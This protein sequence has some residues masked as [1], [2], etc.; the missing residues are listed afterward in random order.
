[1]PKNE[2]PRV[3][4]LLSWHG[5]DRGGVHVP[6]QATG[7]PYGSVIVTGLVQK[8]R[9]LA[10]SIGTGQPCPRWIFM[11]GGP[12]NGK[13]E[14]VEDFLGQLDSELGM[15]GA[16]RAHLTAAFASAPLVPRRVE[17]RAADLTGAPGAFSQRVGR[18]VVVQDATATD[19][20][21]GNAA[22]QL[23]TDVLDLL[24]TPENPVPV[25]VACTN[26]GLLSRALKE[27]FIDFK[28][29]SP[30]TK[31]FAELIRSSSLGLETLKGNRPSCWPLPTFTSVACWPLDQESLLSGAAG[32]ASPVDQVLAKATELPMWE[33]PGRCAD[34]DAAEACPFRQNAEWLRDIDRRATLIRVLRHGELATGQRWNFRDTF[35][36]VAELL[37]GEWGDFDAEH[38]CKWVHGRVE[39]IGDLPGAESLGPALA[40]LS[41]LYPHALFPT[42]WN[43]PAA[44]AMQEEVGDFAEQ[45]VSEAFVGE[46]AHD[47]SEHPKP[48]REKLLQDYARF[49]PAIYTPGAS[50]HV[51]H[52]IETEYSQSVAVGNGVMRTPALA[53]AET[54]FLECLRMAEEEWNLLG[55]ESAVAT[56]FV[57]LL[58]RAATIL[59]KRSVGVRLGHHAYEAE[60]EEFSATLRSANKLGQLKESLRQIL[61]QDG[62]RFNLVESYGQPAA[63]EDRLVVL[64]SDRPGLQ[65]FPAPGPSD[66]APA[67]DVPCFS[68]G[69]NTNYRMPITFDF[70]LALRLRSAG[71]ANSSLPASVRAAIDRVRHRHAGELCRAKGKFADGTVRI[72]V[73]GRSVITLPDENSPPS[74][75]QA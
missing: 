32:A 54:R 5:H 33:T 15:G 36:L 55:R 29:N 68:I 27:A 66:S 35:S 60:L 17:V 58:R 23:A 46:L 4:E 12:G 7:N 75:S 3:K 1:M 2:N 51:L 10:H 18:L 31:L 20:A 61:G 59:V 14:T 6:F 8:L 64:E 48:I 56:K 69:S 21:L 24:T 37:V 19:D 28:G 11:I 73:G 26:R 52:Q 62:F 41:H 43:R 13:S 38:P 45:P 30:A 44:E 74:V 22:K 40:L 71:C 39:A 47:P 50:G 72:V 9:G 25:F 70:F 53:V 34:C 57:Q 65:T 63:E 16:L 42:N 67:H 49:D